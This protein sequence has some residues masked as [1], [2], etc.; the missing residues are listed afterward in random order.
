MGDSERERLTRLWTGKSY[1][2]AVRR[3]TGK[4]ALERYWQEIGSGRPLRD[5]GWTSDGEML[6][7]EEARE[8]HI[9]ILGAPGE[10]KS[11]FI[12]M[13][14]EQDIRAGYGALVL[15][16]SDNGDTVY[17]ILKFCCKHGHE[18]VI[19][20]D[21]NH[22]HEFGKVATI[23]PIHYNAPANV[24]V[25][26]IED[27]VR[28]LWGSRLGDT[29]KIDKYLP[30][31]IRVLHG[32][33]ATLH[34]ALYFTEKNH[35]TYE[36]KRTQM[37]ESL[38]PEHRS[39]ITLEAAYKKGPSLFASEM[40]STFRRFEPFFDDVMKLMVGSNANTLNFQKL[41][42]EGWVILVNLD[43]TGIW[44]EAHQ[45]LLGTMIL[46][47]VIYAISRLRTHGWKGVYYVYIDEVGDYATPK[48][49]Q[50][51]DKKRKSGMRFTLAHQRFDQL[52]DKNVLSAIK[53]ST[54][55]KVLFNVPNRDDRDAMIRM[56]Y[57]GDIPDRQVSYE[58]GQLRKR[59]AAIKINK[60]PPRKTL[61]PNV[62]DIEVDPK[63]FKAFK[64]KLL[65]HEAF[66]SPGEVLDEINARFKQQTRS[67]HPQQS[68]DP[69]EPRK[70]QRSN[71]AVAKRAAKVDGGTNRKA[72]P[73]AP[74]RR[75]FKS[76]FSEEED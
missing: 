60:Q 42:A 29:A 27:T 45:R 71:K 64:E 66:R 34:D 69:D 8:S 47:E 3:K 24:C 49:A 55:I 46:N 59:E 20:I 54:K 31:I 26:N 44:G 2:E 62:P 73:P 11:K 67:V 16:P 57:G 30:A 75:S 1:A 21:P 43:S 40:D 63:V 70:P 5:L 76:V 32:A 17:K 37:L 38:H 4:Q 12:E 15:D 39:V 10:G 33:K 53:G 28:I 51:L 41:V 72:G 22:I 25:G 74:P 56:M 14:V 48:L 7:S 13:L 6:L 50:V 65:Q 52:E 36:K 58:L 35:P 19:V 23:N 9:H 68:G 61:L 18:K